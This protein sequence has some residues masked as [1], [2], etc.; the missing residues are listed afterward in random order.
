[1]PGAAPRRTASPPPACGGFAG[2]GASHSQASST[3]SDRPAAT[4][5]RLSKSRRL[6]RA[7]G[8]ARR[9]GTGGSET[10]AGR[11]SLR[12]GR[13]RIGRSL[14]GRRSSRSARS[15]TPAAE[16]ARET[17]CRDRAARARSAPPAGCSRPGQSR[18]RPGH[19][20]AVVLEKL[21]ERGG[22]GR[23]PR[24]DDQPRGNAEAAVACAGRSR[25]VDAARGSASTAL[26]TRRGTEIP[27]R[28]PA[29]RIR[30]EERP[31]CGVRKRAPR[32]SSTLRIPCV[33]G[34]GRLSRRS[35]RR[36]G[37]SSHREFL[38]PL[39]PACRKHG[40]TGPRPH[41]DEEAVCT[42]AS[43]IVGLVGALHK[44]ARM[45]GG[46]GPEVKD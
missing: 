38:A 46:G 28:A 33:C 35:R 9:D 4:R 22:G 18:E 29:G 26:P 11:P 25:E 13:G 34:G 42:L 32:R 44:E 14:P 21:G 20:R 1:M 2:L 23:R 45:L 36:P 41:P 37:P 39:A 43:P 19:G 30:R 12:R 24:V 31:G 6:S 8:P 27:R 5:R 40:A 3:S 17:A 7:P 15:G 10:G 16:G